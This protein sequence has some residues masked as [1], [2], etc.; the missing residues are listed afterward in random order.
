MNLLE[1]GLDFID[2]IKKF[3]AT[4]LSIIKLIISGNRPYS[5]PN[6]EK[7][8]ASILGNG[9]SLNISLDEHFNFINQ[10]ESFCVNHF[11]TAEIYVVLKP[12]NYVLLDPAFFEKVNIENLRPDIL[13]MM[14]Q[15]IDKTTWKIRLYVPKI[16][17]NTSFIQECSKNLN[18]QIIYFNYTII[19]GFD[20]FKH[21]AFSKKLGF[22]QSQTV[23]VAAIFLAINR[24]FETIFLFGADSSWHESISISENNTIKMKQYHFYE[25]PEDVENLEIVDI[26]KKHTKITL[27]SQ[28]SSLSKTFLG[29]EILQ[30]YAKNCNVSIKNA[31]SKTYIDAFERIKIV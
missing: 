19:K 30:K 29:Y 10:T 6:A 14:N 18:I 15:L 5:L 27:S 20:F 12:Q 24:K 17:K 3:S 2:F 13:N 22:I 28:F 31:S 4:C 25:K 1:T 16:S 8:H 21:W 11:A 26:T 7:K 9:P 23:L